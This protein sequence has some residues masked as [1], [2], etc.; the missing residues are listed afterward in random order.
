MNKSLPRGIALMLALILPTDVAAMALTPA[1][2][3]V[4]LSAAGNDSK[5]DKEGKGGKKESGAANDSAK[6]GKDSSAI[7]EEI[8]QMR[9]LI[10]RLEARVNQ[11]ESEKSAAMVKPATPATESPAAAPDGDREILDFFRDTTISGAV[12][13]YYG[14]NFNRPVGRVNLLRAYDVASNSF[15]LNQAAVSIERAPNVDAGRRFGARRDGA[16]RAFGR[17]RFAPG[18]LGG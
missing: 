2:A 10:E 16:G 3:Q 13:G 1:G 8:R 7:S 18:R 17:R 5:A 12:D 11:L 4:Q 6:D 14:Y 9:Q 15:S